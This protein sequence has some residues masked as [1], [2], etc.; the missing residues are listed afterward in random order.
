MPGMQ[1]GQLLPFISERGSQ[2]YGRGGGGQIMPSA[3]RDRWESRASDR[4]QHPPRSKSTPLGYAHDFLRDNADYDR[5]GRGEFEDSG[6][7]G[8]K[9]GGKSLEEI[10]RVMD[11]DY[12]MDVDQAIAFGVIDKVLHKRSDADGGGEK[13]GDGDT[14]KE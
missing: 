6:G 12:F 5:D 11:R 2:V 7:A 14:K 13:Q 8:G 4:T 9:K 3:A 10:E 1:A